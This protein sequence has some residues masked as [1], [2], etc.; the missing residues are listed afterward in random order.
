MPQLYRIGG[1]ICLAGALA[2]LYFPW[3][4]R[5]LFNRLFPDNTGSLLLILSG[6]CL[7]SCAFLCAG[8]MLNY[9]VLRD[10]LNA[11]EKRIADQ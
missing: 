6:S 5:P 11:L 9:F 2:S 3:M 1:L 7:L 4:F 10:R 8:V